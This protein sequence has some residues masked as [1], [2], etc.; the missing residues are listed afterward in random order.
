MKKSK[1]HPKFR[2]IF[3]NDKDKKVD[4]IVKLSSRYYKKFDT[5]FPFVNMGTVKANLETIE[6]LSRKTEVEYITPST[7]VSS[8]ISEVK[9]SINYERLTKNKHFGEGKTLAVIDTGV[10]PHIDFC[11]IKSALIDFKDCVNDRINPYDDNGHGTMVAGVSISRGGKSGGVFQGI[12]PR[13]KLV[14][15]KSIGKEGVSSTIDI[16][17]GMQYIFDNQFKLSIDVCNMSF[18][19][20]YL[21]LMD[22]IVLGAEKLMDRGVLVVAASGNSGEDTIKSP[23]VSQKILTVGSYETREDK[24]EIAS[25]T[26]RGKSVYGYKPDILTL[27]TNIISCANDGDYKAYTGTSVSSGIISGIALV[28]KEREKIFDSY[29]LKRA[30]ISNHKIFNEKENKYIYF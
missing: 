14:A 27:G 25:Y 11:L 26:S 5:F 17:K 7:K 24:K 23:G 9:E 10:H 19:A 30:I 3:A 12:A 29:A 15:V 22:A 13:S 1:L 6:E 16:L 28:M 20:E 21:G 8:L 18:G 2:N 4:I